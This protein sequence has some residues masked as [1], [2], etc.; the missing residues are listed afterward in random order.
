MFSK[1]TFIVRVKTDSN[2]PVDAGFLH[3][4]AHMTGAMLRDTII[5]T[6]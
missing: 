1:G 2:F 3:A 5:V 6:V 4:K